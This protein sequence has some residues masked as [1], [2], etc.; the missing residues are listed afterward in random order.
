MKKA[1]VKPQLFY[2]DFELSHNIANCSIA[3]DDTKTQANYSDGHTCTYDYT[4]V[5]GEVIFMEGNNKCGV[6]MDYADGYCYQTGTDGL[7]FFHS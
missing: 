2:E 5:I 4:L 7:T 6:P 3:E 1:Y